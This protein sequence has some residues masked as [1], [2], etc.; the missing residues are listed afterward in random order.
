MTTALTL[1]LSQTSDLHHQTLDE[2]LATVQPQ[3]SIQAWPALEVL[4]LELAV[5]WVDDLHIGVGVLLGPHSFQR[6]WSVREAA[7]KLRIDFIMINGIVF[8]VDL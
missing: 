7:Q 5:L 2:C 3:P 6:G 1:Y 8:I 4:V